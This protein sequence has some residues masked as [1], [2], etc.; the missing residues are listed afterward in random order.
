AELTSRTAR[1]L[2]FQRALTALAGDGSLQ[3]VVEAALREA[4]AFLEPLVLVCYR[5][6]GDKMLPIASIG[7][8]DEVM[9]A[10]LTGHLGEAM[11]ARRL[12]VFDRPPDTKYRCEV[13]LATVPVHSAVLAPLQVGD[14]DLGVLAA[15]AVSRPGPQTLAFLAELAVP[16]ALTIA[17]HE[18]SQIA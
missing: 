6:A 4:A 15:G 8:S 18:H 1:D 11:R 2:A 17:R 10:P 9:P 3:A 7:T 13:A 14:R 5:N 12:L 16:L